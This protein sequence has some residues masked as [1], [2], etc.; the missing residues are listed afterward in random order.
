MV[1]AG[2]SRRFSSLRRLALA[3]VLSAGASL[4]GCRDTGVL[5][6][7]SPLTLEVSASRLTASVGQEVEFTVDATGAGLYS[8]V[9]DFGDGAQATEVF[10]Q[11]VYSR[12]GMTKR[13]AYST[14]GTYEVRGTVFSAAYSATGA[15]LERT[16]RVTVT[17]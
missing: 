12:L 4:S 14:P 16:V 8:L 9:L 1:Q 7:A 17:P 11:A 6:N 15:Q 10:D 3:L 2:P 13:H 5:D